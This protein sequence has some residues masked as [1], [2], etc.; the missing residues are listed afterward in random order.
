MAE[1]IDDWSDSGDRPWVAKADFDA[2]GDLLV[3]TGDG[4]YARLPVG[5]SD[6]QL[7]TAR[8]GEATGLRWEM[9]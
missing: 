3:G 2:K 5:S 4:A 6:G 1:V 7:L 9:H 8:S